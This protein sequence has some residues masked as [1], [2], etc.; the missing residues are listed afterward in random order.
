MMNQDTFPV[1]S[2]RQLITAVKAPAF[3]SVADSFGNFGASQVDGWTGDTHPRGD[4]IVSS[5]P[6]PTPSVRLL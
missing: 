5:F 3:D 1:G 4:D 2:A 6:L